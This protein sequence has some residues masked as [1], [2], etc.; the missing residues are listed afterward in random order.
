MAVRTKSTNVRSSSGCGSPSHLKNI[1]FKLSFWDLTSYSGCESTPKPSSVECRW[2]PKPLSGGCG[3]PPKPSTGSCGSQPKPPT[4][5]CRPLSKSPTGDCGL[6]LKLPT[7]GHEGRPEIAVES[8]QIRLYALFFFKK[9]EA[10]IR[11]LHPTTPSEQ[12]LVIVR[13]HSPQTTIKEINDQIGKWLVQGKLRK[14]RE[15]NKMNL[16][17]AQPSLIEKDNDANNELN[18]Y[19]LENS[20]DNSPEEIDE[21]HKYLH[22]N[23]VLNVY[24]ST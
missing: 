21:L 4:G 23:E 24:D 19:F 16:L 2:S 6:L 17:L 12:L 7:G 18:A 8:S 22:S 9:E 5:G 3:S 13:F 20:N 11:S 15:D 14:T 10:Q 1:G